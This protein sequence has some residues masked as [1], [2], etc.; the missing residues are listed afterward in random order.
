MAYFKAK[1]KRSGDKAS[2]LTIKIQTCSIY[3]TQFK[4][5]LYGE[6]RKHVSLT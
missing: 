5:L 6:A 3:A 1:L 4:M 2:V